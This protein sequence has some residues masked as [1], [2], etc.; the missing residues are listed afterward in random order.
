MPQQTSAIDRVHGRFQAI[1]LI[2]FYLLPSL[3]VMP[4]NITLAAAN[5]M[6][7]ITN[8]IKPNANNEDTCNGVDA[9]A[10]SLARVEAILLPEANSDHDKRCA[11]PITNVTAIV[12]P[13][14]R[15]RPSITPP[16]TPVLV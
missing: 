5:T 4:I 13:S 16:T 15:P 12:S 2:L 3:R 7:V 11:L 10:I 9:S 1:L 14:A 8:R 6:K